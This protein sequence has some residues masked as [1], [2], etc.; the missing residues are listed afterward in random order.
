MINQLRIYDIPPENRGPFNDRF[1]DQ[2][3]PIFARYGFRILAMWE[4]ER[5]GRLF[6]IYLLAWA[7]EAEMKAAWQAFMADEEWA[8]IKRVTGAQHGTFV[9][10]IEEHVLH[11]T[12]YSAALG[13]VQ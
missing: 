11:P 3:A 10:G 8:E 9:N 5:E 13:D 6:F 2:A 7:D 1:R 4:S 12:A